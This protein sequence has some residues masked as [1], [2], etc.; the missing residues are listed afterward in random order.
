MHFID[1]CK[2]DIRL[3]KKSEFD[4]LKKAEPQK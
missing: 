3:L 4:Y 1:Y 2:G